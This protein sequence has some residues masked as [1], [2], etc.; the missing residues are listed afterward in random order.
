MLDGGEL[1]LQ[2]VAARLGGVPLLVGGLELVAQPRHLLPQHVALPSQLRYVGV[3]RR[4]LP[5]ALALGGEGRLHLTEAHFQVG[6]AVL[7]LQQGIAQDV[8][9]HAGTA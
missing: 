9:A 7:A 5:G 6:D 2:Q 3:G 8:T 1:S 4:Q